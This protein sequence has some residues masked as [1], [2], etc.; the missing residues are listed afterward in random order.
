[1]KASLNKSSQAPKGSGGS[2]TK[3]QRG[4]V[5]LGPPGV[6]KG[7]QAALA[8]Q[9]NGIS[10]VSSGDLFREAVKSGTELGN[11]AKSYMDKGLLVPDEVTIKM[12]MQKL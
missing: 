9:R 3:L 6:G 1:M 8:S 4:F 11:L 7:T 12:I 5:F 10:H 2:S